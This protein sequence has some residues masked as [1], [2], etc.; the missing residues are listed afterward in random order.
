MRITKVV[1]E[2]E[3]ETTIFCRVYFKVTR[4]IPKGWF[5]W[6]YVEEEAS[7]LYSYAKFWL[8][9]G[10]SAGISVNCRTNEDN[11]GELGNLISLV[12]KTKGEVVL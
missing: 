4:S 8:T 5:K 12:Y 3:T 7:D 6:E 10:S 9:I 2:N 1:F 11:H